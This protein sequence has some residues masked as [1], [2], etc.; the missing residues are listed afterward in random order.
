MTNALHSSIPLQE[1]ICCLPATPS[2]PSSLQQ[3][4][5]TS[6]DTTP[7]SPMS[8][9]A[10]PGWGERERS[11]TFA[12]VAPN[13]PI[14]Y[15]VVLVDVPIHGHC[16][17]DQFLDQDGMTSMQE[18]LRNPR[19]AI[20]IGAHL[21]LASPLYVLYNAYLQISRLNQ[22]A[23]NLQNAGTPPLIISTIR[24]IRHD[25]LGDICVALHQLGMQDFL[26]DLNCFI[27]ENH[28]ALRMHP[29]VFGSSSTPSAPSSSVTHS[30]TMFFRETQT[31]LDRL[32]GTIPLM[33]SHPKYSDA[34]FQ[35]HHLGHL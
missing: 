21:D 32:Q 34:C 8:T 13:S 4:T 11:V 22:V 25:A 10:E 2:S 31:E 18:S 3:S 16:L 30:K 9:L 12:N 24:D 17:V 6:I 14:P 1:R 33:P 26:V 7:S 5:M 35:C 29:P 23:H 20:P 19:L 27:R 28:T 15:P